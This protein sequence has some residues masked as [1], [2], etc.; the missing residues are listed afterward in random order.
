VWI[1]EL[2]ILTD[3]GSSFYVSPPLESPWTYAGE[4]V[5]IS[6]LVLGAA[7]AYLWPTQTSLASR[8]YIHI[9]AVVFILEG[10]IAIPLART[11]ILT[12]DE[13]MSRISA[14]VLIA[15]GAAVLLLVQRNLFFLL[16]QF[17]ELFTWS[18]RMA[19]FATIQVPGLI[20]L[21]TIFWFN[22]FPA[23]TYA[24]AIT[25]VVLFMPAALYARRTIYERVTTH[26]VTGATVVIAII[27][28]A[29]IAASIWFFGS[30]L[31]ER[32]RHA[33][34]W[35]AQRGLALQPHAEIFRQQLRD[36]EGE[37]IEQPAI[38]WSN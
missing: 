19:L 38:R 27:A 6:F 30:P 7:L 35:S 18:E 26:S 32:P 8:L 21:G 16:Q 4:I 12:S 20:L 13:S 2:P 10:T 9:S 22:G 37:K 14:L 25:L 5:A 3:P 36:P 17:W 23:G 1:F 15:L 24:A 11:A 31:L 29:G 34:T 33:V 28:G